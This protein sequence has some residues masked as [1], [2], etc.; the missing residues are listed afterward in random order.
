MIATPQEKIKERAINW[1]AQ[2]E[3]NTSIEPFVEPS[4]SA[5]GGGTL[6]GETLP[7][8]VL[9][10]DCQGVSGGAEEIMGRMRSGDPPV[11]ARIE[12]DHVLLDPRTVSPEEDEALIGG[13]RRVMEY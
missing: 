6:P 3:N 1:Q 8:W 10:L 12:E 11:I 4:R 2:A 13:L 7:S 9:S 5:I